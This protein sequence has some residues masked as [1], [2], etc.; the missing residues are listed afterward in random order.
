MISFAYRAGAVVLAAVIVLG[1][2]AGCGRPAADT[3]GAV[4]VARQPVIAPDYSG[5]VIPPNIAPLNFAVRE[6][7]AEYRVRI[8]STAGDPIEIK[9]S[10][11]SVGIPLKPW[12]KLLA[13]NKG[14][15]LLFDIYARAESGSWRQFD[16]ITNTIAHEPIDSHVVYRLIPPVHHFWDKIEIHQRCVEDFSER[17]LVD[18]RSFERGC[19]N[20]H[21]FKQNQPET[22]S[23]QVR[24]RKYG[25]PMIV[26]KDGE[27]RR[28]DTRKGKNVSPAAYHS[29]HPSGDLVAFS[30]NKPRPFEHTGNNVR[31]VWD[32]NSDLA[33]LFVDEDRVEVPPAIADAEWRETWPSWSSDGKYLYFCR[34][35]QLTADKFAEVRYDLMR[36]AYDRD[37]NVWGQPETLVSGDQVGLS[38]AQPRE[39]PNGRWLLFSMFEYGNFPIFQ[40]SSDLYVTD[41][42]TLKSRRLAI[43]SDLC[44]SWHCWS[45]NSRWVVFA[46]KRG[47]GL[48]ARIYISY[49]DG[50]GRFS[51]SIILPQRDPSFYDSCVRTYNIPELITGP[52]TQTAAQFGAAISEPSPAP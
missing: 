22:M 34:A 30:R 1:M 2:H 31:D 35:P 40:P 42:Q 36:I 48:M 13:A 19:V 4:L 51:R 28:I 6:E 44:E 46:S 5:A 47:N 29:W 16:T 8:S 26:V 41:L 39:S 12:Q 52:V 15:P 25:L 9:T 17:R 45:S 38:T 32:D 43:N 50:T 18:N 10:L 20:C 23:L 11:P 37:T 3:V 27:I 49:V 7:G 21:T 33:I 14:Q 24:S